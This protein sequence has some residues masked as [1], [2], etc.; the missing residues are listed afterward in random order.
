MRIN[1]YLARCGIASRRKAEALVLSGRVTKNGELVHN[2]ATDVK[3]SDQICVDGS[4]VALL[5][6]PILLAYHKPRGRI[7]SHH[8]PFGAPI[9]YDQLPKEQGLFSIGRLDN[10]SEGLLLVTNDGKLAQRIAHPS[11]ETEKEYIVVLDRPFTRSD[12]NILLRGLRVEGTVM[13]MDA[14]QP[15]ISVKED[16]VWEQVLSDWPPTCTSSHI[17]RVILHEGHKRE[18]RRMFAKLHFQVLRLIRIRI[19]SI[20]LEGTLAGEYRQIECDGKEQR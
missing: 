2:L 12:A 7:C 6:E 17:V 15:F 11:N 3:S 5:S 19:G 10:D 9:I 18:I 1:R 13:R 16:G 8:D 4:V 14:I 20:R